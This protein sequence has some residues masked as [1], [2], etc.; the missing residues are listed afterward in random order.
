MIIDIPDRD[1][2]IKVEARS[3]THYVDREFWC[4]ENCQGRWMQNRMVVE[5]ENHR[6]AVLFALVFA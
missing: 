5:F 2:W 1:T 6:D 3:G 4:R